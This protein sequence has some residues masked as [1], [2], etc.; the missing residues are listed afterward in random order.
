MTFRG[1]SMFICLVSLSSVV[2]AAEIRRSDRPVLDEYIVVLKDE[3]AR[4][5]WASQGDLRPTVATVAA[6]MKEQFGIDEVE[7]VWDYVLRGFS[8]GMSE[9]RA[10]EL[11]NDPRVDFVEENGVVT[12]AGIPTT[13]V[14]VTWGLDRIG[15]RALPLST[16]YSYDA[17]GAGVDAYIIDSGILT[18]HVDFE[19]RAA[20]GFDCT[21]EGPGDG[22]GHGTHI[23]ATVGGSTWGVAKGVRLFAVKVLNSQGIGSAACVIAGVNWV[24][25]RSGRRVATL[26]LSGFES[27]AANDAVNTSVFR[28]AFLAVA[29]GNSSAPRSCDVSPAVGYPEDAMIAGGTTATDSR[30][31][32]SNYGTCLDIFAPG[33][34]ITSAWHTSDTATNTISGTSSAAAHVVG[35]AA[36]YLEENP[37]DTPDQVKSALIANATPSTVTD[38]GT[39]SPNRLLYTGPFDCAASS[40]EG[41]VTGAATIPFGNSATVNV[42]VTGGTAPYTV[43]LT[44]GGGMQAGLGPG[45]NFSVSPNTTTAYAIESLRDALEC[46]T[47]A[48]G[49]ATVT[50]VAALPIPIPALSPCGLTILVLLMLG[51]VGWLRFR[52]LY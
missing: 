4:D 27:Q 51:A 43:T 30:W 42:T 29:A 33:D 49:S 50:V 9:A 19:G 16:S 2:S 5:A 1:I 23:A 3:A 12:A 41:S 7:H 47:N 44:N 36:L 35:A 28:G 22:N 6:D 13:Q 45:F 31:P 46:D 26:S 52:R 20:F 15:Q 8:A 11:A 14:P 24:G 25:S 32:S 39:G 10:R 34:A 18:T 40:A 48:S 17:T 37:A 21:G 38:P